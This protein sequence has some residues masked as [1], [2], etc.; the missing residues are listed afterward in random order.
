[1]VLDF[2]SKCSYQT[3]SPTLTKHFSSS[4]LYRGCQLE[5]QQISQ[6]KPWRPKESSTVFSGAEKKSLQLWIPSSAKTSFGKRGK[7]NSLKGYKQASWGTKWIVAFCKNNNNKYIN[8]CMSKQ[9]KNQSRRN[10]RVNKIWLN[11]AGFPPPLELTQ[12]YLI[13]EVNYN[14]V[15]CGCNYAENI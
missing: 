3:V 15:W 12:L 4:V 2:H 9:R 1:M 7:T 11:I 14:I 5:S 6:P 10:N 13:I 8:K